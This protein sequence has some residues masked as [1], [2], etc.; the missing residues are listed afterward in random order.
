MV[1]GGSGLVGTAI[2]SI[3]NNYNYKFIF[4]SSKD[5]DLTI[6][7]QTQKI[8][9]KY[10]P[11]YVIHLAG[12]VG[13]LFRNMN[14]MTDMIEKNLLININVLKCCHEFKV[15]KVVNCLSTCIFPDKTKYPINEEMLHNGPP[16]NS[17]YGYAY[18]KRILE[19]QSKAYNESFG[20]NFVCVIP[21]NIYGKNDNF[22]LKDGHVIPALIHKCYLAKKNNKKFIVKGTGKALRQ[23]IYSEDL[24]KLVM[25]TLEKYDKKDSLILSV[26]EK[27]EVSIE[28]IV[29]LIA[30]NFDYDS[31]I[32]FDSNFSDGQYK[33]TADNSKLMK[34]IKNFNFTSIEDGLE[35]TIKWFNISFNKCRK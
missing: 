29:K 10:K 31:N 23:F 17:N 33:K 13:G 18:S 9:K 22:S 2:N 16:H 3:S 19:I 15:K 8:F 27:D 21:T 7:D 5:A 25:W 11:N 28:K 6:F 4:L 20:N 34:L 1:T 26:N 32:I 14:N 24:A 35:E 30:K 12:F